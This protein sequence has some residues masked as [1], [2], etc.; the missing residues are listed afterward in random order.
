MKLTEE[1]I[2]GIASEHWITIVN[3]TRYAL[4]S[5]DFARAIESTVRQQDAELV[6]E[7][8]DKAG[9]VLTIFGSDEFRQE[10]D[11]EL[12]LPEFAE[13]I[14]RAQQWLELSPSNKTD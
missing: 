7:L 8:V 10:R 3:P 9:W 6:R 11:P 12:W 2:H 1:T 4:A 14:T 5:T 13:T